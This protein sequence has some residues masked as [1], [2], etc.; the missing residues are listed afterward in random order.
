VAY[1]RFLEKLDDLE[2]QHS[3]S[4]QVNYEE[5]CGGGDV[6]RL[7]PAELQHKVSMRPVASQ[8]KAHSKGAKDEEEKEKGGQ[9]DVQ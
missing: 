5:E 1:L 2:D 8:A 7:Q 9:L 4:S 3:E 6:T